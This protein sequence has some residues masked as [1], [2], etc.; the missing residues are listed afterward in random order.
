MYSQPRHGMEVSGTFMLEL[1]KEATAM[2]GRTYYR[3]GLDVV[4][5]GRGEGA[6]QHE[7]LDF[8]VYIR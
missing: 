5:S 4:W 7:N 3:A 2:G 8:R 1:C 6:T